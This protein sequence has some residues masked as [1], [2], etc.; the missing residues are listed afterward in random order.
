MGSA[1]AAEAD[2]HEKFV[3]GYEL[4]EPSTE[5]A[6]CGLCALRDS[7]CAQIPTSRSTATSVASLK[8][9]FKKQ[10]QGIKDFKMD[11]KH[12][13]RLG[14]LAFLLQEFLERYNIHGQLGLI[15]VPN[16][17]KERTMLAGGGSTEASNGDI[18]S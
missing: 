1:A 8:A 18:S 15:Y 3:D 12:S 5:G 10:T 14:Q 9:V 17:N 4:I 2:I 16:A 11:N 6:L 7:I 13:L